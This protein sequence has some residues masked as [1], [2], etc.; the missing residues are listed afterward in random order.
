MMPFVLL[1]SSYTYRF[2][3]AGTNL[4]SDLQ[5][6]ISLLRVTADEKEYVVKIL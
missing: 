6:T 3:L 2:F 1:C 4:R 5:I